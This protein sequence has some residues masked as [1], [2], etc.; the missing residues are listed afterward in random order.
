M[1]KATTNEYTL[2]KYV[3]ITSTPHTNVCNNTHL[4]W[5]TCAFVRP[6]NNDDFFPFKDSIAHWCFAL[7]FYS[8]F[9]TFGFFHTRLHTHAIHKLKL[10]LKSI[11]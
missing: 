4:V 5:L 11:I 10:H 9:I 2:L 8:F 6:Q 3:K 1:L 7:V